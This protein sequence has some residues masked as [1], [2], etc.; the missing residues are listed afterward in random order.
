MYRSLKLYNYKGRTSIGSIKTPSITLR[1]ALPSP[2]SRYPSLYCDH[3]Q[4]KTFYFTRQFVDYTKKSSQAKISTQNGMPSSSSKESKEVTVFQIDRSTT[5]K[6]ASIFSVSQLFA[7]WSWAELT[8]S[9]M[10]NDPTV[11]NLLA[12]TFVVLGASAIGLVK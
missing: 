7:C 9:H 3:L 10:Q 12:G 6:I 8:F 5:I 11:K 1:S 2:L 4:G